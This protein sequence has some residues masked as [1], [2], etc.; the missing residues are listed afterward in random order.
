MMFTKQS[1]KNSY[2]WA[3]DTLHFEDEEPSGTIL[4]NLSITKLQ[5]GKSH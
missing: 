2:Q 4:D 5:K 1:L 3:H